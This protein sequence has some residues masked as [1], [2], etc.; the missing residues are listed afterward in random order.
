[1]CSGPSLAARW[2]SPSWP[3]RRSSAI[4]RLSA[5]WPTFQPPNPQVDVRV[6]PSRPTSSK[7][8]WAITS[9]IA[10]RQI[11]PVQTKQISTWGEVSSAEW[12][13]D[14]DEDTKV[15]DIWSVLPA[16][17]SKKQLEVTYRIGD[18]ELRDIHRGRY[19]PSP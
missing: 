12:G 11:F 9:A 5:F 1:M 3:A 7:A 6:T 8:S 15:S 17:W 10:E 2:L 19:S 18:Y 13:V 16:S 4:A 14:D